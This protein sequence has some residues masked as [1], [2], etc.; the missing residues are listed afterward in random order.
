[1]SV[2]CQVII[3]VMEQ[4]A[5]K[6]LAEKWDNVGLLLG[7]PAQVIKKIR[8]T[9]DVTQG[10]VDQAIQDNIDLLI[11]HHP[12]IFSPVKN[13]RT[14]LPQGKL[15]ASLLTHNIAVYAAHTNLDSATG[16][17]NDILAAKFNLQ[18]TK[19]LTTSYR[20]KLYKLVVFV[21]KTHEEVVS[22]AIWE[23]GAGHI[24]D[25]SHCAFGTP[26][27]GTFLPLDGT[28]PFIGQRGVLERVEEIRLETVVTDK[29]SR[30]V[31]KAM[32]K[33]HP[34]EEVAYDLYELL[35]ETDG[36]GLGRIGKL[37]SPLTLRDFIFQVK[38]ALQIDY[39]SVSGDLDRMVKKVA[40]CGGSGASLISKAAFAGA[41]VFVTG[42]VKYHEGQDG[43]AAGV[44]LIDAGHF[45]T[46]QPIVTFL[47]EYLATRNG[48]DKWQ[49]DISGDIIN[50]DVFRVY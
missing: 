10:V 41:D 1:M 21:P 7:S 34:Y 24:G 44:A 22:Q 20:E 4:L 9:L 5:P 13:I 40:V 16:G 30:R 15:L 18:E 42:D 25:Y 23:A 39:I 45:A 6:Y 12:V 43:L 47:T 38:K 48:A 8:V 46:E 17:V 31:I 11:T 49:V 3:D 37:T 19:P 32:L 50:V 2:K 33:A 26:G 14:D 36:V 29:N 27:Q 35:N 28:K